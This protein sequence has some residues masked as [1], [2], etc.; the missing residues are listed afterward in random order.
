M[1]LAS[2]NV[3]E[4]LGLVLGVAA[5]TTVVFQKIRQPVVVGYLVAGV[6]VGP[7]TPILS[8]ARIEST[9]SPNLA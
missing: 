9:R 7:Y 8:P 5:I 2:H 3:L 1:I 4:D 6:I